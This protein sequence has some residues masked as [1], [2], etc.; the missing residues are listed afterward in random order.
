M[1]N[2]P[3]IEVIRQLDRKLSAVFKVKNRQ[4]PSRGWIHALRKA[5]NISL[6]QMGT[7]LKTSPQAVKGLEDREA[8]GT[9]TIQSLRDAAQAMDMEL[10]YYMVPKEG[11]FED[12]IRQKAR[13]IARQILL[14]TQN[15]M[16][17]EDQ[18]TSQAQLEEALEA[19][20]MDILREMPRY[21]WD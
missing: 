13:E 2:I 7:K 20:T 17:L 16:E 19:K 8:Q 18:G 5:L 12:L 1:I 9:I 4:I 3:K 15:T 10:V 21:L 14:R 11:N 6:V